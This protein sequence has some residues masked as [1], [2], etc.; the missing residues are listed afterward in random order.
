MSG[1]GLLH[2]SPELPF[3]ESVYSNIMD[4][5]EGRIRLVMNPSPQDSDTEE[6][7]LSAAAMSWLLCSALLWYVDE[8]CLNI[9]DDGY[10]IIMS[11]I[12]NEELFPAVTIGM[13][14]GIVEG[15]AADGDAEDLGAFLARGGTYYAITKPLL[16]GHGKALLLVLLLGSV[17]HAMLSMMGR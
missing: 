12:C 16:R 17:V 4:T 10:M 14:R 9:G 7:V 13:L 15:N 5:I 1:I 2:E 8:Q 3:T 6:E 11:S